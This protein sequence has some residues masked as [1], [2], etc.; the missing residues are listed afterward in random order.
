MDHPGASKFILNFEHA[1]PEKQVLEIGADKIDAIVFTGPAAESSDSQSGRHI[2]VHPSGVLNLR[3][4]GGE[5][6]APLCSYDDLKLWAKSS[7]LS[8]CLRNGFVITVV[9]LEFFLDF[10]A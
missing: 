5:V 1:F 8:E 9:I 6:S 3:F 4:I 2:V 10:G 7:A